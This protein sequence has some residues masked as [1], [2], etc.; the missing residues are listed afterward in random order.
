MTMEMMQAKEALLEAFIESEASYEEI[1]EGVTLG[2]QYFAEEVSSVMSAEEA[3][4]IAKI[5][6]LNKRLA[7]LAIVAIIGVAGTIYFYNK[8]KK[9]EDKYD[10]LRKN[11]VFKR[12]FFNLDNDDDE[13]DDDEI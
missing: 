9:A 1:A 4:Y 6:K 2:L 10:W 8:V 3:K 5:A 12:D 13:N 11:T 7:L